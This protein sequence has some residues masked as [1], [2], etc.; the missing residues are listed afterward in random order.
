M[1]EI[2]EQ[3]EKAFSLGLERQVKRIIVENLVPCTGN[4]ILNEAELDL[5]PILPLKALRAIDLARRMSFRV[6]LWETRNVYPGE[7][8]QKGYT[9]CVNA[10]G[11]DLQVESWISY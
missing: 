4:K 11:L 7:R 3:A 8:P 6:S 10:W 1:I 5:G 2:L 9:I